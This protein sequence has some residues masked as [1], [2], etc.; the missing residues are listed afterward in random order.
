[1]W[2]DERKRLIT[3]L[4]DNK[5]YI[6]FIEPVS[7][8]IQRKTSV[9]EVMVHLLTTLTITL[10]HLYKPNMQDHRWYV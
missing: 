5:I 7:V 1:M 6:V 4:K 9:V 10:N 8:V 3:K 2:Q